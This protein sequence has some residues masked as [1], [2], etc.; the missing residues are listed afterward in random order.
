MPQSRAIAPCFSSVTLDGGGLDGQGQEPL[1]VAKQQGGCIE[2]RTHCPV[3][4]LALA[5]DVL[6]WAIRRGA[7]PP[8]IPGEIR[9][10]S[11]RDLKEK[12]G[13][14]LEG[15]E[16]GNS[17]GLPGIRGGGR[18]AATAFVKPAQSHLLAQIRLLQFERV[19]PDLNGAITV[20]PDV[21]DSY[22]ERLWSIMPTNTFSQLRSF[23]FRSQS[24]C[25]EATAS[26]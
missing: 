1:T 5:S 4:G 24:C 13:K 9:Q 8:G 15:F 10:P 21:C 26:L 2:H 22:R 23:S 17:R 7:M 18:T 19:P 16:F 12:R 6:H 25:S 20:G 3:P 14:S 11:P